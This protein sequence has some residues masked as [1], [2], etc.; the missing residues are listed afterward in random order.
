MLYKEVIT[1]LLF[2]AS[3]ISV[4]LVSL[5]VFYPSF[6]LSLFGDDWLAIWRYLIAFGPQSSGKEN[7]LIHFVG[8]YG[9]YEII[10]GSLYN[11]FGS[12][13]HI[14]YI[15]AYIFR[16]IAAFS[17]WP[18]IFFLTGSK[19]A[20]FYAALFLSITTIGLETTNWVFN[21]PSYLAIAFFNLFLY[22]FIKSHINSSKRLFI[23]SAIFFYLAHI[24]APL[25]MTGVLPF[26][27]LLELFLLLRK[28][29]L[30][31]KLSALR[32]LTLFLIFVFISLTGQLLKSGT[33]IQVVSQIL[34]E[35][36][37][38]IIQLLNSGRYE[39]L[40]YPIITVGRIILPDMINSQKN[41]LFFIGATALIIAVRFFFY[42]KRSLL[43]ISFFIA[44]FWTF[45]SFIFTYL[46]APDTLP[47]T[48]HRY[49]ISSTVGI[50]IFFSSIVG[51]GKNI[52]QRTNLFFICLVFIA[53][54]IFTTRTY[55]ESEVIN[56]HGKEAMKKIW[57]DF[58]YVPEIGNSKK[59][60]VFYFESSDKNSRLKHN[61]IS[62]GFPYRMAIQY[63]IYDSYFRMPI[64]MNSWEEVFSAV[65]DGQSLVANG[66]PKEPIPIENIYAFYLDDDNNLINITEDVR[67]KLKSELDGN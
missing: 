21:M 9:A 62:F 3:V 6:S 20:S 43:S 1:K 32:L 7:L 31:W 35:G 48:D 55:L 65:S 49:L 60:L 39:F 23:I 47:S 64:A 18:L 56:S 12:N 5:Y 38:K 19:I 8:A 25:R 30:N 22:F 46:R 57:L 51:L 14:Y 37:S 50:A 45:F 52:R 13:S 26:T 67:N 66:F 15:I 59:P 53:I 63:G 4:V 24:F 40:F 2:P 16:I 17:I 44:I 10:I 61:S 29:V 33:F 42:N 54:N 36:I 41:F 11:I 28:D 27:I 34:S 58:P